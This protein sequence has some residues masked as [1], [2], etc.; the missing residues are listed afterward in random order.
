MPAICELKGPTGRVREH[1]T[2]RSFY[3]RDR[4]MPPSHYGHK[5]TNYI[6]VLAI[7]KISHF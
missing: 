6:D 1:A 5:E 7:T 4:K 3:F 2:W